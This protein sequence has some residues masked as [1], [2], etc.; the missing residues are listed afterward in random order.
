MER[1]KTRS[2]PY[3]PPAE[4]IRHLK[5]LIF[6]SNLKKA[7]LDIETDDCMIPTVVGIYLTHTDEFKQFVRPNIDPNELHRIFEQV[8]AVVTYNGEK[9][10]LEVL[11]RKIGFRLP[12]HVESIDLMFLC[13]DSGLYGGLKKVEKKLG[14]KREEDVESFSGLDAIRLWKEYEFEGNK[15][16]LG[17]LRTYNREDVMNLVALESRLRTL[18]ERKLQEQNPSLNLLIG[19]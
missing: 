18:I 13:W 3:M 1:Q 7:Y 15:L 16:S 4:K 17:L 10:D 5:Y 12:V 14:I 2:N 8:D 9:F 6:H 19:P 11:R